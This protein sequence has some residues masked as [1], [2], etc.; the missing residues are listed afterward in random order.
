MD[1]SMKIFNA[2]AL[3]FQVLMDII[4][5]LSHGILWVKGLTSL[6]F[7]VIGLV[8]MLYV[9]K[10]GYDGGGRFK[11]FMLTALV[12]C[13]IA[14][15]ILNIWFI[16]G[17]AIF[18]VGHVFYFISY[19]CLD[20]FTWKDLIYGACI[21]VV[22]IILLLTY[23]FDFQ[24]IF[25]VILAYAIIISFMVGKAI[26][27]FISGKCSRVARWL[28]LVGSILF[29][30]SDMALLFN[31]FGG[32]GIVADRICLWTYYPAQGLLGLSVYFAA[33]SETKKTKE[34]NETKTTIET[35]EE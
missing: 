27:L 32:M 21:A 18:A 17:A 24:G 6:V 12:L 29:F 33:L 14:D 10:K 13:L 20:R 25:V 16:I 2:I 35:K 22:A 11:Y 19:L 3:P 34:T 23:P 1:K 28:I 9:M 8:N 7:V 30:L 31:I 26:S 5:M 15:V 4:Y